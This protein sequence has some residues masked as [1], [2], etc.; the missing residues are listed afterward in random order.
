VAL[1]VVLALLG[2]VG[3]RAYNDTVKVD[4]STLHI[5]PGLILIASASLCLGFF[6]HGLLWVHMVRGLGYFIG[7]IPGMRA[8]VLSQLGNYIPGKVLLVIIRAHIAAQRGVPAV[9]VAGTVVLESILRNLVAA[10]LAASGLFYYGV[11]TTYLAGL[12][13]LLAASVVVAHPAVFGRLVS[14]ALEKLNR[15]PLPRSL[16]MPRI[17]SLMAGYVLY[18]VFYVSGVFLLARGTLGMDL[19]HLPGLAIAV[20]MAQIG[21]TLAVFAPVGLGVA[22]ATLAEVLALTGAT[23]A[24]GM[25]ALVTRAW[26]TLSEMA[27]IGIAWLLGH[28]GRGAEDELTAADLREL[29][30]TEGE[31]EPAETPPPGE[32]DA[33][34]GLEAPNEAP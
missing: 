33:V 27:A 6:W 13:I 20:L 21:S 29:M 2:W 31:P 28:I 12:G 16:T 8:C 15:P 32:A 22:D 23:P 24:S 9:P 4:W 25:L 34:D 11:G 7:W 5:T 17:L 10:V 14:F 26:R 30:E 19:A 3:W 1:I 18:W